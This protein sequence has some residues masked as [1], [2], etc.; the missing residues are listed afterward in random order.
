VGPGPRE[1]IEIELPLV[2]EAAA[3]DFCGALAAAEA[4]LGDTLDVARVQAGADRVRHIDGRADTTE[5]ADGTLVID[6]SYNANPGSMRAAIRTLSDLAGKTRRT[7]AVLGEM[8]ELGAIA[9]DEH[10]ALGDALAAQHIGVVIGCGG[11]VGLT[12]ARA[13]ALGI[14]VHTAASAAEAARTAVSL[15]RAG[16]VV[17]VKGSRSVG[18]EAVVR[19]LELARGKKEAP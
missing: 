1:I 5:L 2:G 9:E 19:A 13:K 15:A 11:L 3:I 4:M 14:E 10:V 16:D 7:V 6:D 17:L 12:L 18:A 8:K